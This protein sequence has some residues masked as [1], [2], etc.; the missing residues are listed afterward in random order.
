MEFVDAQSPGVL[1][2]VMLAAISQISQ[3]LSGADPY[4]TR[5]LIHWILSD[6][7]SAEREGSP[8]PRGPGG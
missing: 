8:F 7:V 6:V 5:L 1:V 3:L 4:P 2:E